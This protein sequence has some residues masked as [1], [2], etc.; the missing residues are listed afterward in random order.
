MSFNLSDMVH[1]PL[2]AATWVTS[3]VAKRG[4]GKTY[5]G[6][7]ITEEMIKN[8]SPIIVIDPMGVW[9]GLRAPARLPDGSVDPDGKGLPVVVFGGE[10]ADLPL[11]SDKITEMVKAI[12]E[13]NINCVLDLIG[14]SHNASR[15]FVE[16]FLNELYQ[17][18]RAIRTVVL[19]EA[20]IFAPQRPFGNEENMCLSAVD[21]F[22][23]RGGNHNLGVIQ[24]TQ[25]SAALNKNVLS[26]SDCLIILRTL[27]P[28]DKAAIQAWVEEQTDKSKE[29]LK[30]WYDSLKSLK[31]GEAW[32]W[33]PEDTEESKAIFEKVMFRKRET[34]HATRKFLLTPQAANVKLMDVDQFVAK[35]SSVFA[36]TPEKKQLQVVGTSDETKKLLE[37]MK[38]TIEDLNKSRSDLQ[39]V[40]KDLEKKLEDT[41]R[42]A[43][44]EKDRSDKLVT[45]LVAYEA[46]R[47]AL[48]DMVGLDLVES[49]RPMLKDFFKDEGFFKEMA[50]KLSTLIQTSGSTGLV[51]DK[52]EAD[53]EVVVHRE[54]VT[55]E[56]S[57]LRG[58]IAMLIADGELD[59]EL[60]TRSVIARLKQTGWPAPE[61]GVLEEL[62][63]YTKQRILAHDM[64]K[65]G[66]HGWMVRDKERIRVREA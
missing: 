57:T 28:Q 42:E 26:Q 11:L 16:T 23:R 48:R 52:T 49:I 51:V 43:V 41:Q 21:N 5:D 17:I 66:S 33:K 4:A 24:I 60:T 54:K 50:E 38:L 29:A 53:L 22:V 62:T 18:N 6:A 2:E 19:E 10:H 27:A 14:L 12:V 46:F 13:S 1:L 55:A 44:S 45:K 36:V 61:K 9:W 31:N 3:I 15:K 8:K 7:V 30:E 47:T 40:K 25:R 37:S 32:V 34:F 64:K 63:W 35:F 58:Q 39:D 56:E 20:D 65:D 59:K